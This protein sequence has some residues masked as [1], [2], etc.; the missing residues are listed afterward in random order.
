[1]SNRFFEMI[2]DSVA[3]GVIGMTC[4]GRCVRCVFR[5]RLRYRPALNAAMRF[6][7]LALMLL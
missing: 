2:V 1:M 7:T 6:A 4:R 3:P 5:A